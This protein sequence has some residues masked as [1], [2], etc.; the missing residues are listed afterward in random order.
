MDTAEASAAPT[1]SQASTDSTPDYIGTATYS[2]EDNKLRLDPFH[3]LDKDVYERLK[4]AGF[5]WAPHQKIFVAPMWTPNREDLLIE[6]C[7]E[8]GD[9]DKTL[10][11]RQ[12]ERAERFEDYSDNRKK[13]AD[14]AHK[15]VHAIADGI[16]LGQP[17]L[18]GHHSERHARKDAERIENG[19]RKAVKM[20]EQSEYWQRRAEGALRHAKYKE[21]PEVRARR[22]KTLESEIR[23]MI[24]K[25]TP[26]PKTKSIMQHEWNAKPGDPAIPHVWC[27][28]GRGGSWVPVKNLE[29]FKKYYARSIAHNER[30]IAY[31]R[32]ML[33]ES[34]G[35]ITDRF[36]SIEVGGRVLIGSTWE[37][38]IRVTKKDGKALSLRT[39][40]KYGWKYGIEKVKDYEAPTVE[41]A[42]AAKKA[43]KLPPMTNFPSEGAHNITE[44]EWKAR[45]ADYRMTRIAKATETH[46]AYR[47]RVM[48]KGGNLI[49]VFLTDAKRI[50]AP[51][52]TSAAPVVTSSPLRN[53]FIQETAAAT[54]EPPRADLGEMTAAAIERRAQDKPADEDRAKFDA[55][56]QQL[57]QGVKIAVAPQLFPTP[58]WLARRMADEAGIL[59][60]RRVLEPSAGTG[61]IIRA[62]MDNATGA[63]CV[64]IVAVEINPALAQGLEQ[65]RSKTVYA[66]DSNFS[67]HC[68]DFLECNGDLGKF[69]RIL[70]NPPFQNGDDIKHITHAITFLKP[71]GVLV[72]ICANG[73]RQQEKL[74]PLADHW[75]E[76]PADTFKEAGTGVKTVLLTVEA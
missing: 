38:I 47:Y 13:D 49:P 62:I 7:G 2:P 72:A 61:N 68:A 75:E 39:N 45:H 36:D 35:L 69:D 43:T 3:R 66:N 16:P 21:L 48:V 6:L 19:M 4:A 11:E 64:H 67:I 28:K 44:A 57:K 73:P 41:A 27:G 31:E 51:P 25:Y 71:G 33:A 18:V 15:A 5:K 9:E 76:L 17:I 60:G 58:Q 23:V 55:L 56:K 40:G 70:M 63:D 50:E 42:A 8:I 24:S 20:W 1:D 32:A 52:P 74:K 30:R 59:A 26:D 14:A 34:G 29:P 12:E 65:Q 10:V 53:T 37:T 22:I 46:A 54:L